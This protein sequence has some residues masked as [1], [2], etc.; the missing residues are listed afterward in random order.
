MK[1]S[2]LR[3][4]E[5]LCN[6]LAEGELDASEI[7]RLEELVL[8]CDEAAEFYVKFFNVHHALADLQLEDECN[9]YFES[10][11]QEAPSDLLGQEN[12]PS[13]N[14]SIFPLLELENDILSSYGVGASELGAPKTPTNGSFFGR[15]NFS[16][17]P[18]LITIVAAVLILSTVVIFPIYLATR[19]TDPRWAVVARITKT[20]DCQWA[21]GEK[22]SQEGAFLTAGQLLDL[23]VGLAEVEFSSGAKVVLQGPARF[24][25]ASY[26]DSRLDRGRLAAVVPDGAEGFTVRTPG[27]DVVDLGTEFGVAIEG[28]EKADVHVFKGTVEMEAATKS[29]DTKSI[30][31]TK[32]EAAQY[33]KTSCDI[34]HIPVNDHKFV[35]DLESTEGITSNLQV[36]NPSFEVPDIRTVPEYQAEHGDTEFRPIY[37]WKISDKSQTASRVAMYQIS[38]Y[39][40]PDPAFSVGP[41]ATDGRQVVTVSTGNTRRSSWIYQSLGMITPADIGKKLKLSVD[42]GPR[43]DHEMAMQGDGTVFAGFALH[44]TPEQ[45]GTVIGKP[46]TFTSKEPI[47]QLHPLEATTPISV[48]LVG[49]E[50]FVLLAVSDQNGTYG[51]YH[52]DNVRITVENGNAAH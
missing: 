1:P 51:Q 8:S 39:E 40:A 48:E 6:S 35:R 4:L 12:A 23:E 41:G 14:C 50:L 11:L 19:P 49:Q 20:I 34:V 28:E 30:R 10:L 15:I 52:F 43:S 29:G 36:V 24:V 38:P 5:L 22:W 9:E 21:Q 46:N 37:G 18:G 47:K 27:M 45:T 13:S 26:N 33:D 44:V 17:V 42:A 16:F 3:E 32:N 7:R 2:H 25:T 31:L